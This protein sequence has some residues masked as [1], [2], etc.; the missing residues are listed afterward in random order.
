MNATE[1]NNATMFQCVHLPLR[2]VA[3]V[4]ARKRRLNVERQ[5]R[6]RVLRFLQETKRHAQS[7][8]KR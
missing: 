3:T 4:V 1:V 8:V 5:K 2:K 6:K 7:R